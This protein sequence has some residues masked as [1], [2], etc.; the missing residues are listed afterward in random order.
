[1]ANHYQKILVAVDGSKAAELAFKKAIGIA[2]RN[3]ARL[4]LV[5]VIDTR[6]FSLVEAYGQGLVDRAAQNAN[7]LL[8]MYKQQAR[9]AGIV[10]VDYIIEFG[11]PKLRIPKDIAQNNNIDLIICG[12]TGMNSVER[13]LIGSVSENITLH[14][15]CD[16][17]VVRTEKEFT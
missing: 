11:S 7:E 9:S 12:A 14:A 15:P 4:L 17:L 8:D 16:V 10:D 5:H 2:S 13:F 3:Q 6:T 1:M